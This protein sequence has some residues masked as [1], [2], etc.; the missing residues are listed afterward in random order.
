MQIPRKKNNIKFTLILFV[1]LNLI[2]CRSKPEIKPKKI[3]S[4][5]SIVFQLNQPVTIGR[6]KILID[7]AWLIKF[8]EKKKA[9]SELEILEANFISKERIYYLNIEPGEYSI[10]GAYQY[11]PPGKYTVKRNKWYIL[12]KSSL[13]LTRFKVEPFQNLILG[14]LALDYSQ[15]KLGEDKQMDLVAEKICSNFADIQKKDIWDHIVDYIIGGFGAAVNEA[16]YYKVSTFNDSPEKKEEIRKEVKLD[17]EK[18]EWSEI[19]ISK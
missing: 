2:L 5:S 8:D 15:V 14:E 4:S 13:E 9:T 3:E 19:P 1:I 16:S 18:T 11:T 12:D 10:V 17:F 7:K 6:M